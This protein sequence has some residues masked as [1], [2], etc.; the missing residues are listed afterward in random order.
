MMRRCTAIAAGLAL[1]VRSTSLAQAPLPTVRIAGLPFEAYMEPY[2]ADELGYF[3]RAGLDVRIEAFTSGEKASLAVAGGAIDIGMDNP[4]HLAL[5][6]VHGASF[7]VIGGGALY[8]SKSPTTALYVERGAP[9]ANAKD[10]EGKTVA[11]SGLRNIQELAI[12][13]WLADGGADASKVRFI[14]LSNAEMG[15]ALQRG[16]VAAAF[17][18]TPSSTIAMKENDVRLLAN[19]YDAVAPQFYINTWFS[20][21]QYVRRNPEIVKR[22]MGAVYDAA[23]WVNAHPDQSAQILSRIAKL[24]PATLGGMPRVQFDDDLRAAGL[25]RQ[26]EIGVKYGVIDR[27]IRVGEMLGR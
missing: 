18:G 22:L 21:P 23:R 27:P 9:I 8:S 5:A 16:T 10:L 26:L 25:A 19:A 11:L 12:R 20:T 15:S 6:M 17:I 4:I 3:K 2:Y 24:D 7:V 13:A 14:E 1:S